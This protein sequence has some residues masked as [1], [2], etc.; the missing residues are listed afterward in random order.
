MACQ[1]APYIM[2]L[3][4]GYGAKRIDFMGVLQ[5]SRLPDRSQSNPPILRVR[6]SPLNHFAFMVHQSRFCALNDFLKNVPSR[7]SRLF[8]YGN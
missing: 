4:D 7:Q 3:V 8:K 1:I 6:L 5:L 2:R